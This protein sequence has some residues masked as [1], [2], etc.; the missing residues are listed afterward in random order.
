MMETLEPAGHRHASDRSRPKRQVQMTVFAS[1]PGQC[2]ASVVQR[3][4]DRTSVFV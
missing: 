1:W 2:V 4:G 3:N